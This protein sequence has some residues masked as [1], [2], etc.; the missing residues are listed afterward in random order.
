VDLKTSRGIYDDY[1]LQVAA[2]VKA[3]RNFAD[4]QWGKIVR[5]PKVMTD[6]AF[7]V[8]VLGDCYDRQLTEGQLL[9]AVKAALD[10]WRILKGG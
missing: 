7:E 9:G 5:V 8:K 4:I 2:Y 3:A 10:C 6:P 1:H